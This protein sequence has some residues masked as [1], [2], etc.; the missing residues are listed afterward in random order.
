MFRWGH[1]FILIGIYLLIVFLCLAIGVLHTIQTK[2]SRC[3]YHVNKLPNL[4][5]MVCE[6]VERMEYVHLPIPYATQ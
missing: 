4:E 2:T 3:S 6:K 5:T 1:K